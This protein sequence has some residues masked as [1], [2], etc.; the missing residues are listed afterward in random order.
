M[1]DENPTDITPASFAFS[2]WGFIYF[3]LALFCLYSA[4]PRLRHIGNEDEQFPLLTRRIGWL[5]VASNVANAAWICTFVWGTVAAIWI[6]C[7]FITAL[8]GCLIAIYIRADLWKTRR[9]SMLE[10]VAVDV[11]FSVYLGWC[12][13][14]LQLFER[15][16]NSMCARRP[17]RYLQGDRGDDS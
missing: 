14:R 4:V 1:S 5:F 15:S 8:E 2:I 3:L 12:A 16:T 6:S 10:F 17:H 11:A 9:S 7:C 13:R